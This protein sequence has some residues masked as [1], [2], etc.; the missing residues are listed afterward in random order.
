VCELQGQL[1]TMPQQAN[2]DLDFSLEK[3]LAVHMGFILSK[4]DDISSMSTKDL[5]NIR[6]QEET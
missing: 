5:T 4:Q 2:I 3:S 1:P 6:I